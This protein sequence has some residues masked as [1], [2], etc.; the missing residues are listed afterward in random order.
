M[1]PGN[2]SKLNCGELI[3][4]FAGRRRCIDA[5]AVKCASSTDVLIL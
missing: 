1:S 2:L 5:E 4:D 3:L